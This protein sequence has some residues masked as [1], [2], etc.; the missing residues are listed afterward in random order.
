MEE[1]VETCRGLIIAG[2]ETTTN[3]IGRSKRRLAAGLTT[4]MGVQAFVII[5]GI[6]RLLPLTGVTSPSISYRGSSL[7][8]NYILL[9]IVTRISDTTAQRLG[10]VAPRTPSRHRRT[11]SRGTTGDDTFVINAAAP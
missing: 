9:A 8:A 2:H 11:Q 1:L 10:E 4:I 7:A 5:A 3:L 6:T